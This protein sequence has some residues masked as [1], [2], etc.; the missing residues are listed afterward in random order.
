MTMD[1]IPSGSAHRRG[2][3]TFLGVTPMVDVLVEYNGREEHSFVHSCV[4]YESKFRSGAST[5][6]L[7]D[8]LWGFYKGCRRLQWFALGHVGG[9]NSWGLFFF[10]FF[11]IW[12]QT[13]PRDC[14]ETVGRLQAVVDTFPDDCAMQDYKNLM[15]CFQSYLKHVWKK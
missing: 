14:D 7:G 3:W 12:F 11:K 5:W 6:L 10:E 8:Q 1:C 15:F 4:L 2:A 13:A 9:R